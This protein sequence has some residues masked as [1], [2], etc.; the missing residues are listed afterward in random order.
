M[1]HYELFRELAGIR[2][3]DHSF[4]LPLALCSDLAESEKI[5]QAIQLA[6]DGLI[7]LT[8]DDMRGKLIDGRFTEKG[9][10]EIAGHQL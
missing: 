5:A 7:T 1:R 10:A 6:E 4:H 8:S 9:L 3:A 2:Q